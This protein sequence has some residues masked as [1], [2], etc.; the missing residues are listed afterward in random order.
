MGQDRIFFSSLLHFN[1]SVPVTQMCV[2]VPSCRCTYLSI[3]LCVREHSFAFVPLPYHWCHSF[4]CPT[5][6]FHPPWWV[7]SV[8]WAS[9]LNRSPWPLC[10]QSDC[11]RALLPWMAEWSS[12][13][14]NQHQSLLPN[15]MP[16][17]KFAYTSKC[18]LISDLGFRQRLKASLLIK[19]AL[20]PPIL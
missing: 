20:P 6:P 5:L 11:W 18:V 15:H 14:I 9:Q 3:K 13:P 2:Y 16:G 17:H 10:S 1:P 7:L 19:R 8:L 4:I 12:E